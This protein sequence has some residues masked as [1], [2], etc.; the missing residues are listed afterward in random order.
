[1]EGRET[2]DELGR[3]TATFNE[4]LT[5]LPDKWKRRLDMMRFFSSHNTTQ[6]YT[7]GTFPVQAYNSENYDTDAYHDTS[8][9]NSRI[10]IPAG[11]AGYYAIKSSLN[12]AFNANG[13]RYIEIEKGAAGTQGAGTILS[14]EITA[15]SD[16]STIYSTHNVVYLAA[17]EYI[18]TFARHTWGGGALATTGA[19]HH[20]FSAVLL[21]Q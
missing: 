6:N 20:S 14:I 17:G 21:G 9:N 7:T 5:K 13:S 15:P 1:M 10:T 2:R 19:A 4:M 12:F 16:T 8:T 3:L 11:L 18:E